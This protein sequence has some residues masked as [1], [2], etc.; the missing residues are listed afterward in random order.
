MMPGGGSER[1][2]SLYRCQDGAVLALGPFLLSE[3]IS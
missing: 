2:P 3:S 1:G